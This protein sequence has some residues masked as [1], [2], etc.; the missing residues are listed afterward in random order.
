V[1]FS[2][3]DEIAGETMEVSCI[4]GGAVA[5]VEAI[6]GRKVVWATALMCMLWCG[7]VDRAKHRHVLFSWGAIQRELSRIE[8]WR[9]KMR[10]CFVMLVEKLKVGY[11]P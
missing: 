11:L 2:F 10:E 4:S 9:L 3:C 7:P 1:E 8:Q 6:E 5:V